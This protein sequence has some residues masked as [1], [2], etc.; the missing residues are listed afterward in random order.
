MDMHLPGP[1]VAGEGGT[2]SELWNPKSNPWLCAEVL[3]DIAGGYVADYLARQGGP[4][5][6]G[7]AR[8]FINGDNLRRAAIALGMMEADD[9]K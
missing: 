1:R 5:S 9:A 8:A 6:K 4:Y 3:R 2:V 7:G